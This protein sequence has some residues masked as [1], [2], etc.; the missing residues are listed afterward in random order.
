LGHP[1]TIPKDPE[2]FLGDQPVRMFH[3]MK[4]NGEG[5]GCEL[6]VLLS[7][8][9]PLVLQVEEEWTRKEVFYWH[10]FSQKISKKSQSL[11]RTSCPVGTIL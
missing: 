10:G 6:P 3:E 2:S 1:T 5:F 9:N 4:Q 11:L 8:P 7:T